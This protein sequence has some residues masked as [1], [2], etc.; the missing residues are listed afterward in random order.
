MELEEEANEKSSI[1]DRLQEEAV[2]LKKE[3]M[4]S[5]EKLELYVLELISSRVCASFSRN[6][7]LP[8]DFLTTSPGC[9]PSILDILAGGGGKRQT[10]T[11]PGQRHHPVLGEHFRLPYPQLACR[12]SSTKQTK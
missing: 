5:E 7:N 10:Q 2:E 12:T 3:V 11:R 6:Q 4:A 1:L 9:S 8:R